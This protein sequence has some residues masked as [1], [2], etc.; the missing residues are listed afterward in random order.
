MP[1]VVCLLLCLLLPFSAAAESLKR[2]LDNLFWATPAPHP[3][4]GVVLIADADGIRYQYAG[5]YSDWEQKTPLTVDHQFVIG[6]LSKQFT[7][8][9]VLQAV[10]KKQLHLDTQVNKLLP[11][12][13]QPWRQPVTVAQLLTHTSAVQQPMKPLAFTPGSQFSYSNYGYQLLGRL[14]VQVSSQDYASLAEALFA[15][16]QLRHTTTQA[17]N[18]QILSKPHIESKQHQI[19]VSAQRSPE[20]ELPSGGII[21]TA[22]DLAQWNRC[23]H[24]Q[25]LLSDALHRKMV[26]QASV[27]EHRWGTLGYGYGLQ[28]GS[29]PWQEW[30]HSGY[31]PGYIT[32]LSYFPKQKISMV[33]LE[34]VAW[35]S[36][37][38]SRAFFY[39]DQVRQ[40]LFS[41]E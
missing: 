23:L 22:A 6:S 31:I 17:A 21:S 14:L 30:S 33:V 26:T 2:S 13:S 3:F 28:I 41:A 10:D 34:N 9:L 38:M 20:Y 25:G 15:Q 1:T 24:E 29:T 16:C 36:Q 19:E 32:T 37:D 8:A 40:R 27:R 7:A 35:R 39:H 5:G 18:A 11:E 4:S 12:F